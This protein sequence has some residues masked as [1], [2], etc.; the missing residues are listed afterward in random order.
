MEPQGAMERLLALGY[1]TAPPSHAGSPGFAGLAVLL[2]E[3]ASEHQPASIRLRLE[4]GEERTPWA[5]LHAAPGLDWL[6]TICPGH[7]YIH[8]QS[9]IEGTF[10]VFGARWQ[11]E[12]TAPGAVI[13]ISSAAPLLELLP[14]PL[15]PINLLVDE[16]EA[17]WARVEAQLGLT[18]AQMLE[19]MLAVGAEPVYL[20]V[21]QSLQ[22]HLA[23]LNLESHLHSLAK[24]VAGE[25]EWYQRTGRCG[26]YVP[27]LATLLRREN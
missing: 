14:D 20:S 15:A 2:R 7:V 6:P 9:E 23:T 17:L 27:D 24:L 5:R 16:T 1:D 4:E 10:F 19:R 8:S 21:L 18:T 3:D 25:L 22:A 12:E 26:L 13:Q 11:R